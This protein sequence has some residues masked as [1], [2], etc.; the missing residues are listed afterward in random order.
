VIIVVGGTKG[1]VG[2]TTLATNLAVM[3]ALEGGDTLLLDTDRQGSAS[4]W[5]QT[6]E[7]SES[8]LVRVPTMQKF[9]NQAL[10]NELKALS[11]KYQ[12]IFVDAGGYDSQELRASI[13]AANTLIVPIRP[14]QVD[15]WSLPRMFEIITQAQIFNPTLRTLFVI[16]GA[17]AQSSKEIES[18]LNL[19][20]DVE[21]MEFV[22]TVVHQRKAFARSVGLGLGVCELKADPKAE[23]EIRS[24]Y[25]EIINV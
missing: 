15:I 3:D 18:I 13:L 23:A 19:T 1:G 22:Q 10:T 16:N 5:S 17:Q 4:A 20:N 24:L 6:R 9:G 25:E 11:G 8:P 14:A 12:N 21:G 7:A 2:K